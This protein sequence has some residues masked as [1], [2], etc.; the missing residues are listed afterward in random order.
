VGENSEYSTNDTPKWK[1]LGSVIYDRDPATVSLTARGLSPGVYDN[2]YIQCFTTCPPYSVAHPTTND[3]HIAGAFYLDTSFSY[4]VAKAST[5][6]MTVENLLNRDPP[7]V[8]PTQN[9]GNAPK[10][11]NQTLYDVIGRTFRAGVR[12][13]W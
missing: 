6:Y 3:N 7:A 12:F 9:I 1:Y 13:Q 10:G 5:V 4:Q 11:I 8:A 2:A